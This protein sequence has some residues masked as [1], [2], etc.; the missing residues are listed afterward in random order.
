[1]IS[2][3][4]ILVWNPATW[5][6]PRKIVGSR[7]G[8]CFR[9]DLPTELG[10]GEVHQVVHGIDAKDTVTEVQCGW[11]VGF[12]QL[13]PTVGE[14]SNLY[15][16]A[17]LDRRMVRP[18]GLA[19][20]DHPST[21]EWQCSQSG[22]GRRSEVYTAEAWFST[23]SKYWIA[24]KVNPQGCLKGISGHFSWAVKNPWLFGFYTGLYYPVEYCWW[25]K[26]CTTWDAK[27]SRNYLSTRAGFLPST[28]GSSI[29]QH[30]GIPKKSK[31]TDQYNGNSV[32]SDVS[33]P[34][35]WL[36]CCGTD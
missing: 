22:P 11:I 3:T 16:S 27:N 4:R 13:Q 28:A 23:S 21:S 1:M 12:G 33:L 26:S 30:M 6:E 9:H 17:G 8:C 34:S 10:L 31:N 5:E 14:Q 29:A 20:D 32:S 7:N 35:K 18:A 36:L 19:Q 2:P 24:M 25:K 15:T